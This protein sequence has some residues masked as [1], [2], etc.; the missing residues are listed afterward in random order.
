MKIAKFFM[1]YSN[2]AVVVGKIFHFLSIVVLSSLCAVLNEVCVSMD[3][4]FM[5]LTYLDKEHKVC[6]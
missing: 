1:D 4:L 2:N 6:A 3:S 5:H